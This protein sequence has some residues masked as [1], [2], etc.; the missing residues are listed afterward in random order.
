MII[1]I[2][3]LGWLVGVATAITALAPIILMYLWMKDWLK[4]QL[5]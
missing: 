1:S 5:W 2:N 4:K 3:A